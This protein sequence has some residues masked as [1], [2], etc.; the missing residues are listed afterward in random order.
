MKK[1]IFSLYTIIFLY[2]LIFI[3]DL[4]IFDIPIFILTLYCFMV[5]IFYDN[6]ELLGLGI[7]M[8][9]FN[10][11]LQI[12]YI[13]LGITLILF[14]K[15]KIKIVKLSIP[16]VL[17]GVLEFLHVIYQGDI[18]SDYLRWICMLIFLNIGFL[19]KRVNLEKILQFFLFSTL[20][21]MFDILLQYKKIG[22]SF[23][24]II[25]RSLRFGNTAF[26]YMKSHYAIYGDQNM[27]SLF[28]IISLGISLILYHRK[29]EK[30]YLFISF[31]LLIFG[32]LTQ[33]RTF[34]VC[35]FVWVLIELYQAIISKK[36][37]TIKA[38]FTGI[39]I[40]FFIL[41]LY[42]LFYEE[43]SNIILNIFNRF[44][45]KKELTGGRIELFILYINYWLSKPA[46]FLFGIGTQNIKMKSSIFNSPHNFFADIVA[47]F[48]LIG[49][50]LFGLFYYFLYRKIKNYNKHLGKEQFF[51]LISFFIYISFLQYI[52]VPAIFGITLVVYFSLIIN[53]RDVYYE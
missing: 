8:L 1:N 13:L 45:N 4:H 24:Q 53:T 32:L 33:S 41:L 12:N 44:T 9:V 18:V 37:F 2:S 3:R 11:A 5:M 40:F 17:V 51:M 35:L 21:G 48:G 26:L 10:H 46:I 47:S 15:N 36:F 38:L 29:K 14:L 22:I 6:D 20:F 28:C 42:F 34:V 7:S 16:L 19:I 27:I 52:S 30:V 43:I 50:I 39:I 31:L 23:I 25:S 49:C